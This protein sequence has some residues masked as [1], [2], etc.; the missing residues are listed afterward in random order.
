[1]QFGGGDVG[2][3]SHNILMRM[4]MMMTV[5]VTLSVPGTVLSTCGYW[6][7]LSTEKRCE[8]RT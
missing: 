2:E 1:M 8:V 6:L 7:I 3:S 4:T 5:I